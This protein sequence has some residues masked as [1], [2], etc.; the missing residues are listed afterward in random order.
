[1]GSWF[2]TKIHSLSMLGLAADFALSSECLKKVFSNVFFQEAP[3]V[4]IP[5]PDAISHCSQTGLRAAA[6]LG[7]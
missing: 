6:E 3:S 7:W 5:I 4:S 1:M 2:C